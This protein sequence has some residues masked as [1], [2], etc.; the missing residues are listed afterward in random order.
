MDYRKINASLSAELSGKQLTDEA[1]LYVSIRT[2][3]PPNEEQIEELK[4]LGVK[5][6]SAS[7]NMFRARISSRSVSELSDK[8]W[9]SFLSLSQQLRPLI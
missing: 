2:V 4:R 3:A 5:E 9:V 6:A 7:E 1:D 8:P